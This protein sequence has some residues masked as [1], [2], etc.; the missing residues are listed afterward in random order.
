MLR[1]IPAFLLCTLT[2]AASLASA[3]TI[4]AP[5]HSHHSLRRARL[6]VPRW[7]PVLRGSHDSLL[8]QNEEIDR[9]NLTRIADDQ[10]LEELELRGELVPLQESATL[11]I[12][13]NLQ[14]NRRFCRPW[15]R[16][17]VEDLS[18]AFYAEF[19]QP[20]LITSAV[21]TIDQ[22]S[23]LQRWNHNAAP[24]DGDTASSH[25]AGLTVDIGKRVMSRR[26]REWMNQY[27]LRLQ[28]LGMVEAAEER[29]Q[30]C[31]HIMV[32]S[33]YEDYRNPLDTFAVNQ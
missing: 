1:R 18:Q 13:P 28:N 15:T 2:L 16:A 32:S 11:A 21:R 4:R 29:R 5:Y 8:R 3:A 27:V 30:A 14:L 31:Y 26:Q 22:Q 7:N 12:A 6:R 19:H 9:L 23:R 24:I 17:F 10:Q 20:I 25:L 33:R